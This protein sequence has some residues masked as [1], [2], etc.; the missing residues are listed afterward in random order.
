MVSK[1]FNWNSAIFKMRKG[2]LTAHAVYLYI[3]KSPHMKF[4]KWSLFIIG[5]LAIIYLLGPNPDTPIY[6][7]DFPITPDS[8][9]LLDDYVRQ[10]E[11]GHPIKPENEAR[12]VWQNDSL[13]KKT[14]YAVVYLHGFSASQEEG[15]PVHVNFAK[16]FGC[17]LY[18]ARLAEH[19]LDSSD[20]FIN[21]TAEKY[22]ESAKQAL[23]IGAK[24]GEKV[25]LMGTS[26]GCTNALQLAAEYPDKVHA[27][28]LYSPNIEIFDPNAPLLNN[29]WGLQIARLVKKSDH[30]TTADQS[31]TY[32]K[33]WYGKYRIEGVVALQEMMETTMKKEL[34]QKVTQPLLMLYYYKD[35][36]NQDMVVKV[37][38]MQ[39]MFSDVGTPS[40][41]K[42]AVAIPNAGNHVIGSHIKSKDIASVESETEKFARDILAMALLNQ[43]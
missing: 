6:S 20:P 11:D 42:R 7:S 41:L 22:W 5:L 25:I 4:L 32:L 18:L 19:G 13:K 28:I 1:D 16:K 10:I 17:N 27:L 21:L 14:P 33:Y 35:E 24:L 34:F 2:I 26:T 31:E 30:I 29:P 37:S 8:T 43:Q 36:A 39:R 3:W 12:I 40:D 23:A 15:D 9:L 38:A